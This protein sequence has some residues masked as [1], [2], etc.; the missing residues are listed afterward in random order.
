M[1]NDNSNI[2]LINLKSLKLL[3]KIKKIEE[4]LEREIRPGLKKDGGDIELVDVDGDFDADDVTAIENQLTPASISITGA[5]IDVSDNF[6]VTVDVS[7][8]DAGTTLYLKRSVD[9]VND[10]VTNVVGS[11]VTPAAT[12]TDSNPPAGQAFYR[13]TN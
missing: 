5:E 1:F 8:M 2:N 13:V 12:L 3:Q 7:G 6:V 11:V 10:P 4:V 9:L